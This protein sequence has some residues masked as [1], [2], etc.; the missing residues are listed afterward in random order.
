MPQGPTVGGIP[1][2]WSRCLKW[3]SSLF[4]S[5]WRNAS[6][7]RLSWI[8]DLFNCH[9]TCDK[10]WTNSHD[11]PDILWKAW[12]WSSGPHFKKLTI[13]LFMSTFSCPVTN[14]DVCCLFKDTL[15]YILLFI[16]TT[17]KKWTVPFR[18]AYKMR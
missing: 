6:T 18:S 17:Q 16:M 11:P 14:R 9:K 4:S 8:S 10:M 5:Q 1:S 7:T 15:E 3:P 2:R 12:S 13:F